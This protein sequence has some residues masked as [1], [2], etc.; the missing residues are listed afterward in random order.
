M[1]TLWIIFGIMAVIAVCVAISDDFKEKIMRA[2]ITLVILVISAAFIS[3]THII[4]IGK[5][6]ASL[7]DGE[8]YERVSIS[9]DIDSSK[10]VMRLKQGG[11]SRFY[12]IEAWKLRNDSFIILA[13]EEI[14]LKFSVREREIILPERLPGDHMQY[15]VY[16]LYP[17][18]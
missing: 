18:E 10:V 11:N 16:V 3:H 15:L 1:V 4:T 6:C 9:Q 7:E 14:P 5:P 17:V 2:L 13:K 12:E 8:I